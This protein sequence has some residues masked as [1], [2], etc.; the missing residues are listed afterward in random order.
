M[1][2]DKLPRVVHLITTLNIGGAEMMLFRLL[3]LM[4]S[5]RF[6]SRVISLVPPGPVGD[7]IS[8][9]GIPV[10]TINMQYGKPTLKA[11]SHLT[12][13]LK[14]LR[15]DILQ[16]W[17]YHADLL[18]L[19][20]G[21]MAKVPAILWNVRSSNMDMSQYRLMSKMTVQACSFLSRFPQGVV[22]NSQS[23]LDFHKS[24]GYRPRQWELIP[25]GVDIERFKPDPD[26]RQTLRAEWDVVDDETVVG[27]VARYDPMK[28]HAGFLRSAKYIL[29][30]VPDVVFVLC[31]SEVNRDN[32]ALRNMINKLGLHSRVRLIGPRRDIERVQAAVDIAVSASLFGEGFPNVIA[33]AMACGI[34]V[35]ATDVGDS[36]VIVGETGVIVPPG[37]SEIF[38]RAVQ[39]L[40]LEGKEIQQKLGNRARKR[41]TN[42][43]SLE[44]AVSSYE[45][46]YSEYSSQNVTKNRTISNIT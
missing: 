22:I 19:L 15:P 10:E 5:A 37:R 35:V 17:L 29:E 36:K 8:E 6:E 34:P 40:I 46:I 7:M 3:K 27:Y 11:L 31:G 26:A 28:D 39:R 30:Q 44:N 32:S 18:G 12:R 33:E 16:T 24:I 25:N 21:R 23:G 42:Y 20:S 13:R 9:L 38:A 4:D 41:V 45:R 2:R 43:Y 14:K 1:G